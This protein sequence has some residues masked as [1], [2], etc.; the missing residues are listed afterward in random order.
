MYICSLIDCSVRHTHTLKHHPRARQLTSADAHTDLCT[1]NLV[2]FS[3]DSGRGS[4][5]FTA[6][7]GTQEL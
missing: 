4:P 6:R 1:D 7:K 2:P 5:C 3:N